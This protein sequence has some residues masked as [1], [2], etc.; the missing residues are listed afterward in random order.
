M[1]TTFISLPISLA[2]F[3]TYCPTLRSLSLTKGWSNK[4]NFLELLLDFAS[5]NLL[6]HLRLLRLE[7]A[8]WESSS[9]SPIILRINTIFIYKLRVHRSNLHSNVSR[10][11]SA[12]VASV[13]FKWQHREVAATVDVASVNGAIFLNSN[14]HPRV[15]VLSILATF[16]VRTS[17]VDPWNGSSKKTSISRSPFTSASAAIASTNSTNSSFFDTVRSQS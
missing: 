6:N 12:D 2:H 14:Y 15:K 8:Q 5:N 7:P 4:A 9:R 3:S 17:L 11:F 1:D 16:A 13:W 10:S